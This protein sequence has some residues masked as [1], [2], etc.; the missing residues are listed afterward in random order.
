MTTYAVTSNLD[1]GPGALRQAIAL[2]NAKPGST[3]VFDNTINL[4]TL[5]SGE[6]QIFASMT[7][8]GPGANVLTVQRDPP[9]VCF[10]LVIFHF[11]IHKYF[12]RRKKI[13]Y[14]Y[15]IIF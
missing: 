2:A 13:N 14:Y 9:P 1:S 6:L 8:N 5:T 12:T 11:I 3:I 10:I 15:K 4:V 7:I